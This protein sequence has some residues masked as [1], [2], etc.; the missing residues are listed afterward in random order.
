MA[1]VPYLA[2]LLLAIG[3]Y[4]DVFPQAYHWDEVTQTIVSFTM[5]QQHSYRLSEK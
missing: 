2:T 3:A 1:N 5:G 4:I